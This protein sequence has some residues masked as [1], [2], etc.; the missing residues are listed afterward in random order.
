MTVYFDIVDCLSS[1]VKLWESP[2]II[3]DVGFS[4]IPPSNQSIESINNLLL[5]YHNR[6]S[7]IVYK[8]TSG[9]KIEEENSTVLIGLV[10]NDTLIVNKYYSIMKPPPNLTLKFFQGTASMA[11]L[12]VWTNIVFEKNDQLNDNNVTIT[13]ISGTVNGTLLLGVENLNQ[14]KIIILQRIFRDDIPM[15]VL[16]LYQT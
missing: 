1:P 16:E 14:E 11:D 7:P 10:N 2:P 4:P 6:T 9:I 13:F 5:N 12:D 15:G 3:H 8:Y